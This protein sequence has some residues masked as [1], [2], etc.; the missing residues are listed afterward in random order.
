[1]APSLSSLPPP[2]KKRKVRKDT[3]LAQSIQQL[4]V[5]LTRAIAENRSLNPLAD[6][7]DLTLATKILSDT[8]KAIYA[9]YRVLVIVITSDKLGPGGD[10][11]V[12][13]VKSWLWDNLNTYVEY[14]GSLL[15]DEE[16]TLRVSFC[17]HPYSH[18][19]S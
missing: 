11:A 15:K 19:H 10:G 6:L 8:S 4:E 14:L 1:M 13:A 3:T 18:T 12:K 16:K 5:D 7:L 17:I 2:N 9:F